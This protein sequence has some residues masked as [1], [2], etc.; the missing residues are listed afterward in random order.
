MAHISW[1][2]I[3]G[4]HSVRKT[5]QKYPELM[6]G[7][8][9]ITYRPKVKLH[10]TN[11]GVQVRT[12]DTVIAQSRTRYITPGDD[13]AGFA[14][15]VKANQMR[16]LRCR[17]G[18]DFIVFGE[19]C[20]PGIMK[21]TGVNN[22][23]QPVFAIFGLRFLDDED[24]LIVTPGLLIDMLEPLLGEDVYIIPW[25]GTSVTLDPLGDR[26]VLQPVLD[27]IESEVQR[28][29]ERCPF[30]ASLGAEGIGE[31]LVYYPTSHPGKENFS[32]LAFK[33]KGQ[34]HRVVKSK[35]SVQVDPEVASSIG[36]FVSLLVTPTRCEQGA[37]AVNRGELTFDTRLIGPFIGWVGKDVK[38]ESTAELEA[39]G[40]EW[41][42]VAKAVG[43]AARTWYLERLKDL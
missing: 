32:N 20:G 28:V 13:N 41:K 35:K 36:E 33:A 19:W 9:T 27:G 38:K 34:K 5:L 12:G 37:R 7:R 16:F 14:A 22:L 15:W 31:G 6:R 3:E 2:D 39:S 21:G 1:S 26:D 10:G 11:A 42:Q 8:A 29:E 40:L 30:A 17:R 43:T 24:S 4:F 23:S 25:H 18:R